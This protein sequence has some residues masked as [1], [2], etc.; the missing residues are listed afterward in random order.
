MCSEPPSEA[1]PVPQPPRK[2]AKE[3]ASLVET[4]LMMQVRYKG[5]RIARL[6]C[7]IK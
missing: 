1:G 6:S 3:A 7:A 5:G 4:R 2:L